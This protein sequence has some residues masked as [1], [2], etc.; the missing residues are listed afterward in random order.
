MLSRIP[1]VITLAGS[2]AD[3]AVHQENA[4]IVDYNNSDQ[5]AEGIFALLNDS[6]LREKMIDNAFLS[7]QQ[8]DIKNHIQRL[9]QFYIGEFE[10]K[11]K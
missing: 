5:I 11:K 1:S 3:Y 7:A 9:E 4:W 10:K 2:A 6:P 8:Y